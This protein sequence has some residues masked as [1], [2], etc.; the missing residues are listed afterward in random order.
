MRKRIFNILILLLFA[1][2][3]QGG[4]GRAQDVLIV[5]H[6]ATSLTEEQKNSNP[7]ILFYPLHMMGKMPEMHCHVE[8]PL[9]DTI[10]HEYVDLGLS[11][12]WAT[13]N[14]G[15]TTP[16]EYGDYFAWG[17]TEPK[18]VYS[19]ET[20]KWC[21]PVDTSITKYNSND[22][23]Q[24][25]LPEDDAATVNWGGEWRMPTKEE[26]AELRLSC[27][28]EWTT[29]NGINGNKITG[30]NGN[31]IF[32]PM[33]G[34]YN[35]FNDQ[36]NGL[37]KQGWIYSSTKSSSD[38]QAQEMGTSTG[39]A[40][41]TSCSR[42][43]GLTIRPVCEKPKEKVYYYGLTDEQ[44]AQA[45]SVWNRSG[46]GWAIKDQSPI[47]GRMLYGIRM[48]V[49]QAGSFNMYK[50]PSLTEKS[51]DNLQLVATVTATETGLQDIDFVQPFYLGENEYLVVCRPSEASTTTLLGNH[52]T[53][54]TMIQPFYRL[55]GTT[56][57]ALANVSSLIIDFY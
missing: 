18:E 12:L 37:G 16:E 22:G 8:E 47:Q 28:W 39:G 32:I 56:N 10:T 31:S 13:C 41:Q 45:T 26:L 17:E 49:A 25:L 35:T 3:L 1:L 15:A 36:L 44:F 38:R 9:P 27:T 55:V 33:G 11:V 53:S 23:M 21:N 51:E 54:N 50:A 20:Y 19:W 40:S 29:L 52:M 42:C 5:P 7:T 6:D 14:V 24:T 30:P 2:L 4:W 46:M 48:K 43:V 34:S 57:V